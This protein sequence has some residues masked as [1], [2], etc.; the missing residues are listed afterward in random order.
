MNERQPLTAALRDT[1]QT[2]KERKT[3]GRM[4]TEHSIFIPTSLMKDKSEETEAFVKAARH[5]NNT[6][7]WSCPVLPEPLTTGKVAGV[8]FVFQ[9]SSDTK[10]DE[11]I[12]YLNA[13]L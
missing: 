5:I 4:K 9:F 6:A 7:E 3:V 10:Y 11:I 2:F 1:V 8:E 12:N 13:R